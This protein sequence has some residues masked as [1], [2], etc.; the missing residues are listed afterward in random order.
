MKL[1]TKNPSKLGLDVDS[2]ENYHWKNLLL[3]GIG[4]IIVQLDTI[5]LLKLNIRHLYFQ[6]SAKMIQIDQLMTNTAGCLK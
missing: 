3:S 5:T 6:L 2:C 4:T 1:E